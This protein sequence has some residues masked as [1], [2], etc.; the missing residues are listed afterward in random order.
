MRFLRKR[1]YVQPLRK[2]LRACETSLKLNVHSVEIFIRT[3][4][5]KNARLFRSGHLRPY[6]ARIGIRYSFNNG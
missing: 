3:R 1:S 4:T 6:S 5:E 2:K